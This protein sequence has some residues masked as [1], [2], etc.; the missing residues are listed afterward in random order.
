MSA[1]EPARRL[2]AGDAGGGSNNDMCASRYGFGLGLFLMLA[3]TSAMAAPNGAPSASSAGGSVAYPSC[4]GKVVSGAE[5]E[6]AHKI[7]LAGRVQYDDSNWDAAIS[8]FRE[9]YR[10]D[11]TKHE[12][13]IILSRAYE[14]K[15]ER[16]EARL[17]LQT[18]L[19]RVP[20][21]PDATALRS[22]LAN[23]QR[24][25]EKDDE[26]ARQTS[27]MAA[28][29]P[30]PPPA[31]ASAAVTEP[32]A[33]PSEHRGHTALPWVVAG[34]GAAALTTGIV[35]LVTAPAIPPNCSEQSSTCAFRDGVT[36]DKATPEQIA[37]NDR[38]SKQANDAVAMN[39]AGTVTAIAGGALVLGGLAWHFLEPTGPADADR[40]RASLP[41]I[42]PFVGL[43]TAG[44]S[45]AGTF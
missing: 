15:G 3:S 30:T 36:R 42:A 45:L 6:A 29:S 25:I 19:E 12:L 35:L 13:L 26:K 11:C 40:P 44:L 37:Q 8:Q 10:R 2:S 1:C 24:Q 23:I 27:D 39:L 38:D 41:R 5:S 28:P 16:R 33:A 20:D 18:F 4:A 14:A 31:P 7:Y 21:S 32:P 43:R 17:A 34:V 9:A 22:R